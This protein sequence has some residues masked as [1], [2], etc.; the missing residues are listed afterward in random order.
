MELSRN[1]KPGDAIGDGGVSDALDPSGRYQMG[2]PYGADPYR[3][4]PYRSTSPHNQQ[5]YQNRGYDYVDHFNDMRFRSR[6]PGPEFLRG[7]ATDEYI[8]R[9]QAARSK[10][11]TNDGY[12]YGSRPSAPNNYGPTSTGLT[13]TSSI[14]GTPDFIPASRYTSPPSPHGANVPYRQQE[15][16]R[17]P[18]PLSTGPEVTQSSKNFNSYALNNGHPNSMHPA[19]RGMH[20]PPIS[21]MHGVSPSSS[22]GSSAAPPPR[23]QHATSFEHETPSSNLPGHHPSGLPNHNSW[24]TSEQLN[25]SRSPGVGAI[26]GGFPENNE[27]DRYVE[28]TVF[29]KRQDNGFGFRIVGGTEEGSQVSSR[30]SHC[31][32]HSRWENNCM[33]WKTSTCYRHQSICSTMQDTF[34][35]IFQNF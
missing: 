22:G 23:R 3:G 8:T 31:L 35:K 24:Q 14:S 1:P 6:T 11:P 2:G 34:P 20:A 27:D 7:N 10:T 28:L 5:D 13:Q 9:P 15:R 26:N 32:T 19:H 17:P 25:R 18:R 29:L 33:W 21:G 4:G 30:A 16:S 12:L